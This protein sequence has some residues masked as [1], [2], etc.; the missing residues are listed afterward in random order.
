MAETLCIAIVGAESSGKTTLARTLAERLAQA[1]HRRVAWVP[2]VLRE[3]CEQQGRTP[4]QHE[5]AG[6]MQAQHAR[7]AAAAALHDI[8]V[9]DTTALMTTVYSRIV[10]GD[11]S[12]DVQAVALHRG[13]ALTLLTALDLPWVADGLQRDGP[14]VQ[15]PVDDALRE[16][17]LAQRMPFAVVSGQ[18]ERRVD[19]A[20]AALAPL[21]SGPARST[22]LFTRLQQG[23]HGARGA[24]ACECC[25]PQA[26]QALF[27]SAPKTP[28]PGAPAA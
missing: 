19:N 10:F 28:A 22:G 17:L 11:R 12:L 15:G 13:M 14:Q 3:W 8:V 5:Q 21:L 23:R 25:N 1:G 18:G 27:S 9:C 24:W 2:E 6:L 16:L 4:I 20:M 26:E 7:I